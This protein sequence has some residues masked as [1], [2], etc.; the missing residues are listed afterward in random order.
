MGVGA[1]INDVAFQLS[2]SKS[3][4]RLLKSGPGETRRFVFPADPLKSTAAA[5]KTADLVMTSPCRVPDA[6]AHTHRASAHGRGAARL[7]TR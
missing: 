3:S 2:P 4:F 6:H 5:L 1:R 7:S